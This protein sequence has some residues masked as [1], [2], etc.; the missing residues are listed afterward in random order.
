MA[1]AFADVI[2]GNGQASLPM[3]SRLTVAGMQIAALGDVPYRE[4]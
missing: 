1:S 2:I 4:P 3:A